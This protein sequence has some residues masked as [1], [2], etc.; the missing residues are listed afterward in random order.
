V[1]ERT[2]IECEK[3]CLFIACAAA[4]VRCVHGGVRS[5]LVW[6]RL[7]VCSSVCCTRSGVR[8][9]RAGAGGVRCVLGGVRSFVRLQLQEKKIETKKD[10]VFLPVE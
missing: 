6:R 3:K 9:L 4:C 8:S 10:S 7:F 2:E 5:L 1:R